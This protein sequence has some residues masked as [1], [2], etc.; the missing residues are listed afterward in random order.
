MTDI[1]TPRTW[2]SPED[3]PAETIVVGWDG[4]PHAD[5]ALAWALEH[6]RLERRPV[7]L[8]HGITPG[9]YGEV[10][11]TWA[12]EEQLL[13]TADSIL[14]EAQDRLDARREGIE[15]HV[16][17]TVGDPRHVLTDLS[18]RARMLVVG[19]HGRGS[20]RSKLLGSVGVAVVRDAE[21]PVVVIRPTEVTGADGGVLV[22]VDVDNETASEVA[23]FAFHE[24]SVLRL[25]LTVVHAVRED[26]PPPLLALARRRLS[27]AVGGLRQEYPEVRCTLVLQR[28]ITD[29]VVIDQA[30]GRNLTVVGAPRHPRKHLSTTASRLV[31]H[32][33]NP[34]VVVPT[35]GHEEGDRTAAAESAGSPT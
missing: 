29:E 11:V 28:G 33:T 23:R 20:V 25:P 15:I 18:R 16:L 34:I 13:R 35:V 32:S 8:A 9:A 24:A 10:A 6:A 26:I 2:T 1:W 19:S 22:G 31:E 3:V 5:A 12:G 17:A 30:E 7:T 27:E 21:C 4:S 14:V